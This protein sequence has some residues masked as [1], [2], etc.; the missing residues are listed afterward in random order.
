MS[1]AAE[2]PS[3]RA[4]LP[5][6]DSL[7]QMLTNPKVKDNFGPNLGPKTRLK[8]VVT[9]KSRQ[10]MMRTAVLAGLVAAA[11]AFSPAALPGSMQLRGN[12]AGETPFPSDS[13]PAAV[14]RKPLEAMGWIAARAW[15]IQRTGRWSTRTGSAGDGWDSP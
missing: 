10:E 9:H 4:R 8:P 13:A 3:S 1:R 2:S 6:I 14:T 15:L 7:C 5:P 11:S 12:S